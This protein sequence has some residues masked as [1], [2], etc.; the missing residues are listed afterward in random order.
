MIETE[1]GHTSFG[2]IT[3]KAPETKG[4]YEICSLLVPS[5]E[6]SNEF[7]FLENAYR[8]TLTVE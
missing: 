6:S 7:T 3:L 5:P 4:K 2:I 1:E 8:F